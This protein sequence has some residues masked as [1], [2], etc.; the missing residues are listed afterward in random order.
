MSRLTYRKGIDLLIEIIPKVCSK[1]DNVTFI[2]GGDGPKRAR[3]EEIRDRYAIHEHV[4][5]LGTIPHT[6]VRQVASR[7][8]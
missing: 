4:T 1:Y 8:S 6:Q 3:L 7:Y 5:M 2:I